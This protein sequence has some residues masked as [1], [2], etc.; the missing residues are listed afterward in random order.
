HHVRRS[1]A[2]AHQDVEARDLPGRRHTS[3]DRVAAHDLV[4]GQA[5]ATRSRLSPE[6]ATLALI[7]VSAAL[8]LAAG[9]WAGLCY[10]ES[11]YFACALHPSLA[12]FDHPPLSILLASLSILTGDVGRL[13]LRWPFIA[14]FA[15]TTWLLFLI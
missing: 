14:L 4:T 9:K 15:G 10:G 11:Y 7:A 3:P 1:A 6:T 8:R 12:Y 13:T 2:R 5:S